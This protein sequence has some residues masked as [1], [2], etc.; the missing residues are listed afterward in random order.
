MSSCT[1]LSPFRS[2]REHVTRDEWQYHGQLCREYASVL[3]SRNILVSECCRLVANDIDDP[4]RRGVDAQDA[5]CLV[6]EGAEDV[7]RA[8]RQRDHV[9]RPEARWRVLLAFQERFHAALQHEQALHIRMPV[10][11]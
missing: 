11:G 7:R 4:G 5:Q 6:A 2:G 1:W 8:G 9:A 10:H 3:S